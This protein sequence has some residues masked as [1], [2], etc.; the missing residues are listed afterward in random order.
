MKLYSGELPYV[1]LP[2]SPCLKVVVLGV[3]VG[4]LAF[5]RGDNRPSLPRSSPAECPATLPLDPILR[6]PVLP[7]DRR[8]VSAEKELSKRLEDTLNGTDS[9]LV[10]V[11]H[12]GETVLEWSHGRIKSNESIKHDDRKVGPD[13][14]WRVASITKVSGH[15]EETD[16]GVYCS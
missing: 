15:E 10:L 16:V 13:T 6:H 11:L 4:A 8:F 12:G 7:G 3:L 9:A 5:R 1:Q 14:I 2:S